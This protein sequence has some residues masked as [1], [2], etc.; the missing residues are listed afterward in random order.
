MT[1]D[2]SSSIASRSNALCI[3]AYAVSAPMTFP[4]SRMGMEAAER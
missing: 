4:P 1:N 3:G 2:E